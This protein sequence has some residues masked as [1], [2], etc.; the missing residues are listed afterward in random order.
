MTRPSQDY[1]RYT[2]SADEPWWSEVSG[3]DDVRYQRALRLSRFRRD[4]VRAPG[5]FTRT[6][7]LDYR[8]R[9]LAGWREYLETGTV[10]K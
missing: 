9:C 4:L 1:H 7:K 2:A 5:V 10:S 6:W 8:R 3:A